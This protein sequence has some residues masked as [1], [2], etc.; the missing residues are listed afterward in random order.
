MRLF[1]ANERDE[2]LPGIGIAGR[3]MDDGELVRTE[4]WEKLLRALRP[5]V[6]VTCWSTPPL[7]EEWIS[8]L[9]CP[10]SYVC[11]VTGSVRG[12]VPRSFLERG[13]HVTNWGQVAGREVAEH[14]L[15][16]AMAA[17]RRMP[18][19]RRVRV[20]GDGMPATAQLRT[21]TLYGRRVGVHGFGKV[22]RSLLQLLKPFD[23][24]V[25]A[26]SEGVPPAFMRAHQVRPCA[27]LEEL[28]ACSEVLF[29]CEALTP[30]SRGSVNA[31]VL[32]VLPDGAV[33]VNVGRGQVVDESALVREAARGRL[34]VA[35]DVAEAEPPQC[36][37][38]IGVLPDVILSPHIAGPT[39]EH[40]A[41]CGEFALE[42]IGRFLRG[43]PLE[44]E[45]DLDIYDRS[46]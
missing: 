27:S 19:W 25:S 26:F 2:Y 17:L 35:L 39:Y 7:P 8:A 40:Y 28:C 44:A 5:E 14:A 32:S 10:L 18:G 16:L 36:D 29:E 21:R 42:N 12:V 43:E 34:L 3:R 23:V 37:S 24:E 9:D 33:F 20:T 31:E 4:S 30:E 15:L 1:F 41:R 11:H 13:G 45:V 22:A 38:P 6:L 46:T